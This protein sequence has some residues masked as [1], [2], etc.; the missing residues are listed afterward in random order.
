MRNPVLASLL[1]AAAASA[2]S[3]QPLPVD[4]QFCNIDCTSAAANATCALGIVGGSAIN[5]MRGD[6]VALPTDDGVELVGDAA[7]PT[8][9][10]GEIALL[11]AALELR[12]SQGPGACA[13][14]FD[15]VRGTVLLP[16]PG[17]GHLAEAEIEVV[18]QPM[19]SI[20]LELGRNLIPSD[21][22]WCLPEF[23][24]D[25][26]CTDF[27]LDEVP[28]LRTDSHYFSFDVD[29]RYVFSIAGFELPS[30]PGVAATFILDTQDP[31]FFLTGSA[32]GIPGLKTPLN[33][34]SGGFGFSWNDEIPF[35][36]LSTFPFGDAIEPFQG[37]YAARLRLPIMETDDGRV[38]VILDG[39]LIASLDPDQDADHPFL[40]PAAF[41]ANP[42]LAL[43]ANG[44]F[45]VRFSPFAKKD[46]KAK[47]PKPG[48][49][50]KEPKPPKEPKPT[51]SKNVQ[52]E[53][54]KAKKSG[55]GNSLLAI[56]LDLAQATALG[57]V[58]PTFTELYLSGEAGDGQSLLPEFMPLPVKAGVGVKLGAYFSTK[59]EDTF[60]QAL[61][62]FGI[63]TSVLASWAKLDS[64]GVVNTTE[65]FLRVDKDGFLIGGTTHNSMH[66]SVAPSGS[67]GVEALI[68][69]NGIDTSLTLSGSM[70]VG[71]ETLPDGKLTLSPRGLEVSGTLVFAEHEFAMT[72]KFGN[73]GGT[74]TGSAEIGG[75]FSTEHLDEAVALASLI[76]EKSL[77]VRLGEQALVIAERDLAN[78]AAAFADVSAALD[79]A[80]AA[81][82]TL[83][84]Q[85]AAID[86]QIAQLISD[87]NVQINRDCNADFTGC[88]SCGSCGTCN[89]RCSCGT[90]DFA[91]HADCA[92]CGVALAACETARTACLG[93]REAC[94]IANIVI[95][96]ADRAAKIAA[97]TAQIVLKEAEKAALV[98]SRDVALGALNLAQTAVNSA[99]AVVQVAEAAVEATL[100]GLNAARAGLALLQ[101]QLD[102]IPSVEGQVAALLSIDITTGPSGSQKTGRMAATFQGRKVANGRVDF[103]ASPPIACLT[104]PTLGELCAPL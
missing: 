55:L 84:N 7:I 86:V 61:G 38:S 102:N 54:K 15:I 93:A 103:D 70:T 20:G 16:L 74:L 25:C 56:T 97:L 66:P 64:L 100:T 12:L 78:A 69:P 39:S 32:M 99:L 57:R 52:S 33:A 44:D 51:T 85:I 94:R 28:V 45:N 3:A 29:S 43:G 31:Y 83:N 17:A 62:G 4:M 36:P 96:N 87:R 50:G 95:C 48:K 30:T 2:A 98:V 71:G 82:N 8:G 60:V 104:V 77:E 92:A 21:S 46:P 26:D 90:F 79:I 24:I 72:G 18:E 63:D 67:L 76:L 11:E 65:G 73:D 88:P 23:G 41:L 37:G 80:I 53:G 14:G 6:L 42:D 1:L 35:V 68:A 58:H 101:Q 34:S 91:C 40:S 59:P 9:D 47:P 89:S 13:A 22:P 81:V 27:C 19:A 5:A 10:G 49:P 75:F